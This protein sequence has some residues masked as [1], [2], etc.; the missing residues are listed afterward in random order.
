MLW[1]SEPKTVLDK[2]TGGEITTTFTPSGRRLRACLHRSGGAQIGE[3]T[4]GGSPHL[5]C[6]C[7][8]IKREIIRTG[9]LPHLPGIPHLHVNRP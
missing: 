3:V 2:V 1:N 7:D 5:L 9:G 4:C 8:Q 6:T